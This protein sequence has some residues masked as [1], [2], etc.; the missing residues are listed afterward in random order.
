MR[1]RE[2]VDREL[3]ERL[4][5]RRVWLVV[6]D[7]DRSVADLH[8][9]D[10]AGDDALLAGQFGNERDSPSRLDRGD[11]AFAKQDGD[12]DR[13][14]GGRREAGLVGGNVVDG[15]GCGLGG[16]DHDVAHERSVEKRLDGEVEVGFRAGDG[17]GRRLRSSCF[18]LLS[19]L[20]DHPPTY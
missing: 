1:Q 3:R 11:V 5:G 6:K 4:V 7:A 18:I 8:E 20:Q 12:F 14:R 16:V 19:L 15:V 13:N 2:R 9:I 10:V 17:D